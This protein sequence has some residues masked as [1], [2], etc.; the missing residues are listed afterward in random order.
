MKQSMLQQGDLSYLYLFLS[1]PN[2]LPPNTLPGGS[3][4]FKMCDIPIFSLSYLKKTFLFHYTN[5]FHNLF[6]CHLLKRLALINSRIT[7]LSKASIHFAFIH[8]YILQ[9]Q[10]ATGLMFGCFPYFKLYSLLSVKGVKTV[11]CVFLNSSYIH[12]SLK[13]VFLNWNICFD[14]QW[15]FSI[16]HKDALN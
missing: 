9:P 12:C 3:S 2:I 5:I 11:I 4:W 6:V 14:F 15:Q 7:P 10:N 16:E 13:D 8:F 1:L